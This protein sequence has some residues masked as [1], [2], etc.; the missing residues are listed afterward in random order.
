M[1]PT[2]RRS[3]GARRKLIDC[4]ER[5]DRYRAALE[6]GADPKVVAGWI[7]EV[8]GERLRAEQAVVLAHRDSLTAE[9]VR[10]VLAELPDMR[11]VLAKADPELKGEINA[12]LGIR[13]TYKPAER[14]VAVEGTPTRVPQYVSEGGLA[15]R[16]NSPATARVV[17]L[18][19]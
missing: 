18:A 7:G 1:T 16:S 14:I 10:A 3:E 17:A 11:K 4:D 5:L 2:K 13:L 9:D 6:G 19:S 15:A 8:Q 12:G